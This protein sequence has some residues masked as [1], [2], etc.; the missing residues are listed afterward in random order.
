ML[1]VLNLIL[2]LLKVNDLH[3]YHL[4][5]SVVKARGGRR[6]EK[7][8]RINR[9]RSK[10]AYELLNVAIGVAHIMFLLTTLHRKKEQVWNIIIIQSLDSIA[11]WLGNHDDTHTHTHAHTHTHTLIFIQYTDHIAVRH[12]GER[13]IERGSLQ[14]DLHN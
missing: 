14:H 5:R 2:C 1:N 9:T 4:L 13:R 3:R 10:N 7:R 6:R 12:S 8:L 11:S